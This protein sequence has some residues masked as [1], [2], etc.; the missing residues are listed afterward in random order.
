MAAHPTTNKIEEKGK[1]QK[2]KEIYMMSQYND[3]LNEKKKKGFKEWSEMNGAA[4]GVHGQGN[5][6]H[7]LLELGKQRCLSIATDSL[8]NGN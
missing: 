6:V 1:R 2:S 3:Q 5:D 4:D 8:E 7:G